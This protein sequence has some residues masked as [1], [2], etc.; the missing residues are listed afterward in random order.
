M[1]GVIYINKKR[2]IGVCI[3]LILYSIVYMGLKHKHK[4]QNENMTSYQRQMKINKFMEKHNNLEEPEENLQIGTDGGYV[5]I[6]LENKKDLLKVVDLDTMLLIGDEIIQNIEG[7]EGIYDEGKSSNLESYFNEN[8]EKILR[9]SGISSIDT[10]K[11]VINRIEELINQEHKITRAVIEEDSL[12]TNDDNARFK[13]ILSNDD[14]EKSFNITIN[15][16]KS[17]NISLI[18]E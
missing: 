18:W 13:L 16:I 11:S 17:E 10:Y 2:A 15:D 4:V 8:K 1:N 7:I 14:I 12:I 5:G 9:I 3:L 6:M